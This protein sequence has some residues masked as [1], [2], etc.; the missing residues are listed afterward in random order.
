MDGLGETPRPAV[1]KGGG[2]AKHDF[3][4]QCFRRIRNEAH[5]AKIISTTHVIV[6]SGLQGA[7]QPDRLFI[8]G[9]A[10]QRDYALALAQSIDAD[11]MG[12]IGEGLQGGEQLLISPPGEPNLKTGKPKVASDEEIA[13]DRSK[14]GQVG[15]AWRL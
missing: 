1:T 9:P 11:L 6:G 10:Q 8:T 5:I 7:V 4:T 15:S 13:S 12:L 3:T 14:A 2:R